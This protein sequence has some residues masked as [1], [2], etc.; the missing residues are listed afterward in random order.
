M[1]AIILAAGSGSRLA[2]LGLTTP[3]VLVPILNKPLLNHHLDA[4]ASYVDEVVV[5]IGPNSFG[6]QISENIYNQSWPVPVTPVIQEQPLGTANAYQAAAKTISGDHRLLCLNGDDLYSP[7][8][9][10]QLLQY[11]FAVLGQPVTDPEKWGILNADQHGQLI[12]LIEKPAQ[13]MG[14]LAYTGAALLSTEIFTLYH[15]VKPSSRGEYEFTETVT[16]FAQLH[17]I[18][19]IQVNDYWLPIGY[20]WH[21]LDAHRKLTNQPVLG[22]NIKMGQDVSITG[23]SVIG[24]NV[25]IGDNVMIVDSTIFENTL[26][27]PDSQI[28]HSVIGQNAKLGSTLQIK[29]TSQAAPTVHSAIKGQLIDT[30]RQ[31]LGAAIGDNVQIGDRVTIN[32]GC[33]IWPNLEVAADAQVTADLQD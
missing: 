13:F 9:I 4:I 21:I 28:S 27:G 3:K 2:P 22:Q 30:Q 11:E 1:K 32:A 31:Y 12:Q 18:Q 23:S 25:T 5:V 15:H 20:P 24:D 14:N 8:D 19:T 16:A 7:Q 29:S 17:H 10:K 33:K 6:Q 26:I